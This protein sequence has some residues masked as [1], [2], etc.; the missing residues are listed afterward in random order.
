MKKSTCRAL[1]TAVAMTPFLLSG[2]GVTKPAPTPAPAPAA[3]PVRVE[4][5][6][7]TQWVATAS[8]LQEEIYPAAYAC[9]G[10]R[11]TRWSSP[12]SD[13]QWLQ[14]DFGREATVCGLTILWEDAYSSE[15]SILVSPDGAA[16][17]EVYSMHSGDG[18][19]TRFTSSP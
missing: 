11:E 8:A 14:I 9:D 7:K 5:P 15:Y 12:A 1:M 16:W 17:T 4:P 18:R 6:P 19:R 13:P 2:C 10:K 3:P